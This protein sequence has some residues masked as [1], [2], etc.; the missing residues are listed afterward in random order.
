MECFVQYIHCYPCMVLSGLIL[1]FFRRPPSFYTSKQHSILAEEC[2]HKLLLIYIRTP[3][4]APKTVDLTLGLYR[5]LV[6]FGSP[7][8]ELL[9]H[10]RYYGGHMA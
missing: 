6:L 3:S 8:M 4:V 5:A 1:F 2:Y 10:H 7:I 9:F